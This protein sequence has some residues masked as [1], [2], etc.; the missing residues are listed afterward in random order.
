[1]LFTSSFKDVFEVWTSYHFLRSLF[2]FVQLIAVCV[3]YASRRVY[4]VLPLNYR[5]DQ[6]V[7]TGIEP[8]SLHYKWILVDCWLRLLCMVARRHHRVY[9]HLKLKC[10]RDF[11]LQLYYTIFICIC[12]ALFEIIFH[13][14]SDNCKFYLVVQISSEVRGF[15]S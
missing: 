10:A 6:Q 11:P 14:F 8:A 15:L 12:Q 3:S 5:P 13:D 1:M 2:Q 4:S 7:R 9:K